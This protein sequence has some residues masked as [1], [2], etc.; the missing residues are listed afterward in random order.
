MAIFHHFKA[1]FVADM[2]FFEVCHFLCTWKPQMEPCTCTQKEISQHHTFHSLV[3][4]R[5]WLC[6]VYLR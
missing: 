4:K 3:L 5:K 1:K 2:V 6:R